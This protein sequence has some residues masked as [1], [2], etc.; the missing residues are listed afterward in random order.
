MVSFFSLFFLLLLIAPLLLSL[1][2]DGFYRYPALR[3]ALLLA[4]SAKVPS[5]SFA[6]VLASI[7]LHISGYPPKCTLV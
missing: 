7:Y 4:C 3:P 2:S 1:A 6:G 5:S